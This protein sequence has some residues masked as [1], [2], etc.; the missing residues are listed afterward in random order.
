MTFS[1]LVLCFLVSF[2]T[3]VGVVVV[4]RATKPS[5]RNCLYWHDCSLSA[6]LGRPN[7]PSERCIGSR[8]DL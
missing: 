5:C 6:Q 3:V 2:Y 8:S 4:R 1:L 7:L